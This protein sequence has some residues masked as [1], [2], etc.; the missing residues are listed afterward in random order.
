MCNLNKFLGK[1]KERG[2]T[3]ETLAVAA[4]IS[5]ATLSRRIKEP[6]N[7]TIKEIE[8]LSI[9]L[10]LSG[11]EAIDIFLCDNSLKCETNAV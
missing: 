10:Q 8:K 5:R 7:L 2:Y 9:A 1:I 3:Q 11:K 6:E 4:G